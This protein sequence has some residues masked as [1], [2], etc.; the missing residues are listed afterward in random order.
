ML[1]CFDADHSTLNAEVLTKDS[2]LALF[3][4]EE[5]NGATILPTDCMTCGS[6]ASTDVGVS[7]SDLP[8]RSICCVSEGVLR[9]HPVASFIQG[10][11]AP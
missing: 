6:S 7:L 5:D 4:V 2:P 9:L 3:Q 1:E 8:E 11:C 10:S